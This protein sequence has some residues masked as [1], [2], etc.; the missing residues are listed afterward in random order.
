[1]TVEDAHTVS[2]VYADAEVEQRTVHPFA[3]P[4]GFKKRHH[5]ETVD[6]MRRYA[7]NVLDTVRGERERLRGLAEEDRDRTFEEWAHLY[8][9]HPVT[10][11]VARGLVWEFRDARGR[12]TAARPTAPGGE[13][14]TADGR[15][16]PAPDDK[17]PVRLWRAD[18]ASDDEVA[19]WREHFARA[20][21]RPS[22]DQGAGAP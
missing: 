7:K 13:S 3:A 22:F 21:V 6:W 1:M 15:T 14:T 11:V 18:R 17:D 19:A 20:G 9:D 4:H 16:L 8:R 10:G 5:A 2:L 12:W